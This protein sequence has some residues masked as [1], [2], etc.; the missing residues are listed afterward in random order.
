M[1][2]TVSSFLW[3]MISIMLMVIHLF[4]SLDINNINVLPYMIGVGVTVIIAI[5]SFKR[6]SV[7]MQADAYKKIIKIIIKKWWTW[8]YL[9]FIFIFLGSTIFFLNQ[10]FLDE[11]SISKKVAL[12]GNYW[13]GF[14]LSFIVAIFF[15]AF[16]IYWMRIRMLRIN[17]K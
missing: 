16:L 8:V 14:L 13:N 3:I 15:T 9:I 4:L 1:K 12:S 17:V 5:I 6:M 2:T 11:Y 10:L 7:F